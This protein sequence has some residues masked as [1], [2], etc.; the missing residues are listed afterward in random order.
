MQN[1]RFPSK[2]SLCLKKVCRGGSLSVCRQLQSFFVWK[3][4]ATKL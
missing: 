3:L 1:G 4:L 2:I